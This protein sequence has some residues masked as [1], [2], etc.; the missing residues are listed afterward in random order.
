MDWMA[1]I[2]GF[3]LETL[4]WLAVARSPSASWPA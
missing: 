3:G 4:A 1:T 2:G